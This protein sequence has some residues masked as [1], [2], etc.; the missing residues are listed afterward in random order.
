MFKIHVNVKSD[1]CAR[2][3]NVERCQSVALVNR[4]RS[5]VISGFRRD[6]QRYVALTGIYEGFG[7]KCR[8]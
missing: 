8:S 4:E 5:V 7:T 3:R 1:T 6:V 2:R